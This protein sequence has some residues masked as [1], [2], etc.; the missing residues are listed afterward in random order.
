MNRQR[1]HEDFQA[2]AEDLIARGI[3]S[4]RRL[5]VM[6]GSQGGLFMGA[7]LTQRPDLINAAVIQVPLFD[8]LRFHTLLA[9]ASWMGEYGNPDIAEQREWIA[10]YSPYQALSADADYPEVFIHTSTKDD[11][12]HPGHARKAAAQLEALGHEVLF[13]ENTDGGHAAG[14]NLR[15]TAR[16]LALE[17]T[18]LT[19]RL[20]D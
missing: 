11:R 3:T 16:R 8:M 5:G 1:A 12:V 13:Y 19:R 18:Y 4:P 15:E 10:A 20:M 7:M 6:G 9:G 17:Y 2:V 14:A